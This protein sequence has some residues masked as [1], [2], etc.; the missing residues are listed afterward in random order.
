M[1]ASENTIA[2]SMGVGMVDIAVNHQFVCGA[3]FGNSWKTI[4]ACSGPLSARCPFLFPAFPD[5]C[6]NCFHS[7]ARMKIFSEILSSQHLY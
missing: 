6:A 1:E 5:S 7:G 4:S 2:L 3:H